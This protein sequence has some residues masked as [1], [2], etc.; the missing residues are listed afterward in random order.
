MDYFEDTVKT[1][2][3]REGY[4][5]RQSFKVELTRDEKLEVMQDPRRASIPRVEVDLL[6][7]DAQKNNVLVLEVKSLINSLGVQIKELKEEHEIPQG[8][9]KLFTS[10]NYKRVVFKRLKSQLMQ[11]QMASETTT[12]QLGLAA[13]KVH[14][15]GET[16][17]E[18]D[19]LFKQNDWEFWSPQL[20]KS[21]L[22]K[23]AGDGYENNP[24]VLAAKILLGTKGDS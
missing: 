8:R 17:A 18:F 3:E 13:G 16:S 22:E 5:V 6:V 10:A 1:I 11:L 20:I 2:L 15:W 14:R 9:Y 12:L 21:K 4:W 19:K 7:F 23:M 24:T